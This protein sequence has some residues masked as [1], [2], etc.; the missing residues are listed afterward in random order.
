M[1]ASIY[2]IDFSCTVSLSETCLKPK[3]VSL[4]FILYYCA[5]STCA[6][7]SSTDSLLECVVNLR[8]DANPVAV[9]NINKPLLLSLGSFCCPS[10]QAPNFKTRRICSSKFAFLVLYTVRSPKAE[11]PSRSPKAGSSSY[12]RGY[13][14]IA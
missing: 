7:S 9:A 2:N 4:S 1:S 13:T 14:C 10:V 8:Y 6:T 5:T 12:A 11:S 3:W